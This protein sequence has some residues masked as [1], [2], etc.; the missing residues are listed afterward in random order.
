MAS[1]CCSLGGVEVRHERFSLFPPVVVAVS[2]TVPDDLEDEGS[3]RLLTLVLSRVEVL[4]IVLESPLSSAGKLIM[5]TKG[6]SSKYS[7]RDFS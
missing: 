3:W 6:L 7:D 4:A 5:Q 2:P 1:F